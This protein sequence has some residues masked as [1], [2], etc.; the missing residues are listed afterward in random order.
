MEKLRVSEPTTEECGGRIRRT[1]LRSGELVEYVK[2]WSGPLASDTARRLTKDKTRMNRIARRRLA[3]RRKFLKERK[4]ILSERRAELI[5]KMYDLDGDGK[6]SMS[7]FRSLLNDIYSPPTDDD[8][9]ML[10]Q[11]CAG[12]NPGVGQPR[13]A[14]VHPAPADNMLT[15]SEALSALVKYER[16]LAEVA[17]VACS[18]A[19]SLSSMA[20]LDEFAELLELE[21][22]E[23]ELERQE[24]SIEMQDDDRDQPADIESLSQG[25]DQVC[26]P[27]EMMRVKDAA[28]KRKARIARCA[29]M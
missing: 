3:R 9:V 8:V 18:V 23:R 24:R 26:P 29:V 20:E 6:L 2:S 14:R 27:G 15:P 16:V 12:R 25:R 10:M 13:G 4:R 1:K 5:R 7:E 28:A 19:E 11:M 21:R 17:T 22:Q